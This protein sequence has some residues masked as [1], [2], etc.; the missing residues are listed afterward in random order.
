[1][2]ENSNIQEEPV[3]RPC[4]EKNRL[5][6][7]SIVAGQVKSYSLKDKAKN[8]VSGIGDM[9]KENYV[10]NEEYMRR[11]EICRQCPH[12]LNVITN[13]YNPDRVTK[14]DK[15]MAC[16]CFLIA[17]VG[18]LRGKCWLKNQDCPLGKWKV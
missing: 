3:C 14:A 8:L 2:E 7:G 1:M 6:E 16:D 17:Q 5:I 12:R 11:K 10:S 13:K 18:K 9:L 15:C 4:E